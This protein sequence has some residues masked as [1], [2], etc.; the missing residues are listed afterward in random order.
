MFFLLY[1][2][3]MYS[4]EMH[5]TT[6]HR[7]ADGTKTNGPASRV[8]CLHTLGTGL[9]YGRINHELLFNVA[10]FRAMAWLWVGFPLRD[11]S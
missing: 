2:M 1:L 9:R 11:M 10:R 4:L 8:V 5:A 7:W 6:S 3:S